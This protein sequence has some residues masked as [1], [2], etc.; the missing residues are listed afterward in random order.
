MLS[1]ALEFKKSLFDDNFMIPVKEEK[2]RSLK[3]YID[4]PLHFAFA[5]V[6]VF[7]LFFL[8]WG[9]LAPLTVLP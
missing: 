6:G 8:V 9:S 5:A 7:I 1:E 4:Q 2:L 3:H